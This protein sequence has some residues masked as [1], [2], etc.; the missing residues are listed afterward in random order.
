LYLS[1][2]SS[3]DEVKQ[4]IQVALKNGA[5]GVSFFGNVTPQVLDILK[6]ELAGVNS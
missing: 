4:G 6:G 3:D 1:D 2:F 5:S